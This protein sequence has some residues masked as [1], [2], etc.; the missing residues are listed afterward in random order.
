MALLS[1]HRRRM[2]QLHSFT[3][4]SAIRTPFGADPQP[5]PAASRLVISPHWHQPPL[6]SFAL[7][8]FTPEQSTP[9]SAKVTMPAERN[10]LTSSSRAATNSNRGPRGQARGGRGGGS[11]ARRRGGYKSYEGPIFSPYETL[12]LSQT[13]DPG[14]TTK[15]DAAPGIKSLTFGANFD[16]TE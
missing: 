5:P 16:V 1:L 11:G 14:F 15:L 8:Y 12:Y 4:V 7:P 3:L 13:P 9:S 10:A 2:F 6:S